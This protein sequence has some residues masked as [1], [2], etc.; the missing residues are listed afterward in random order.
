M[1]GALPTPRVTVCLLGGFRLLKLD[2]P[3]AVRPGGKMEA[4]LS[5][6]ALQEHNRAP[7]EWLLDAMWPGSDPVRASQALNSLVHAA[8]K[9]L[10]DALDGGAPVVCA[11][12]SYELNLPAGVSVDV[13]EFD[14]RAGRAEHGFR[15]GDVAG[16]LGWS[17][18]A[19]EVYR[20]DLRAVEGVRGLVEHERL[21][22]R[23]LSLLGMV[24]DHY[25][26][27]THY[28]TALEYALRLLG[29]DSCR[30]DAHRLVMRCHVRLGERAQAFRQ[31]HTCRRMLADE[32]GVRPE[33]LTESLF[34]QVR[35][36]PGAV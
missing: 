20:G 4:L 1:S 15:H 18:T 25:F 11:G 33:P 3:V 32:F 29:H 9:L 12:G 30:E 8:R 36:S 10:E 5:R 34:E 14:E 6:L 2:S 27:A 24:A 28:R 21:R 7:R 35:T 23:Y 26:R 16:A 22:A 13:A 19:I 17:L 31:Y